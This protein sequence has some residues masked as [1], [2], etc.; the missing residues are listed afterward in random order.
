MPILIAP[1]AGMLSDR[2]GG[3]P[4]MA[5]GLAL[6]ATGLAWIGAIL[7]TTWFDDPLRPTR[8]LDLLGFGAADPEAMVGALREICAVQADDGV[9]FDADDV[10]VDRIRDEQEYGGFR[11]KTRA[12]VAGARVRVFIIGANLPSCVLESNVIPA[13]DDSRITVE[14]RM[15]AHR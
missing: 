3:C 13:W 10:V 15:A 2:I 11:I 5:T 6:Q 4:I 9:T 12:T 14:Y 1:I 8:D 7:T